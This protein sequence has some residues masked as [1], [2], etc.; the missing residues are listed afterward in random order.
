[1]KNVFILLLL[2]LSAPVL[3]QSAATVYRT[4]DEDGVVS[5]SD[6]PP[7]GDLPVEAV[8]LDV[9][10]AQDPSAY[11][12]NLEAMRKSTDR[13]AADRRAR[14]KHRAELREL[15]ARSEPQ[16]VQA[17]QNL[18]DQYSTGWYGSYNSGGYYHPGRPPWRPGYRPKPEHPIHRPPVRPLPAQ[19]I[20][21][22]SQLMRPIIPRGR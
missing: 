2:G 14:E 21:N 20:E 16:P 19:T 22:N 10:A 11:Q 18:V 3:A 9:P 17:P 7:E 6:T 5:F 8:T 4:V 12:E 1:M 15:A 13:M